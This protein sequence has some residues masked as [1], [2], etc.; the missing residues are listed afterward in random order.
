MRARRPRG[1]PRAADRPGWPP[2]LP[3]Q[4]HDDPLRG[5]ALG[6]LRRR[7]AAGLRDALGAARHLG[8]L[9]RR[10]SPSMSA[11]RSRPA[12]G[13]CWCRPAPTRCTASTGCAS[14]A[15]PG[16][17]RTS[18]SSR[19]RPRSAPRPGRPRSTPTAAKPLS[20]ARSTAASPRTACSPPGRWMCRAGPSARLDPARIEAVRRDGAVLNH[21][22]WPRAPLPQPGR[23]GVRVR[24]RGPQRGGRPC[25]PLPKARS[26]PGTPGQWRDDARLPAR[27]RGQRRR[28]RRPADRRAAAPRP[29]PGFR[30]R[31]RRAHGGAGRGAACSRC[32]SCR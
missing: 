27:R 16:R 24:L 26:S 29:R 32:A 12:P 13:W 28:A 19:S 17:W 23:G 8:L 30:R 31:R 4:G 21:R 6:H 9:R 20:S 10:N 7:R 5:R 15:R 25:T 1:E 3:G 2:R 22:D 14:P 11:P 18:A